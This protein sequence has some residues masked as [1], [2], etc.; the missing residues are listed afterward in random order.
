M[1]YFTHTYNIP[2][3]LIDLFIENTCN[4]DSL[5]ILQRFQLFLKSYFRGLGKFISSLF[6]LPLVDTFDGLP[7]VA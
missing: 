2:F 5:M 3:A 4:Q 7:L 1:V 6:T